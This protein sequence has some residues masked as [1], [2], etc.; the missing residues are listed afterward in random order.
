MSIITIGTKLKS[1]TIKD[2]GN[3]YN[4]AHLVQSLEREVVFVSDTGYRFSD[5]SYSRFKFLAK[6][7][8]LGITSICV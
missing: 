2:L 7:I 8:E 3:H 5:G 1:A 6:E 4:G